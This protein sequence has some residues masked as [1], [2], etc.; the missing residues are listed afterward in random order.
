MTDNPSSPNGG[1]AP[2]TEQPGP[3][4]SILTQYVKDLSFENPR[5]PY[6]LQAG[7]A[8]PEIQ[9]Q[10]DVR[11][12]PIADG[13]YEVV[14]DLNVNAQ[15]GDTSVFLVELAYGGLFTLEN[16]PQ[17]SL[18]P[19]LLIECPRLLFPFA[20]RVVADATRDGG[21]PPLMID[22]IDFVTLFRRRVQQSGES[23]QA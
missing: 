18:Q 1:A 20:R 5:A 7:Q 16:I 9:I 8:R 21:F 2:S 19:L 15:S 13:Q 22:P 10:V 17:D 14:L 12:A 3:R 23:A 6:G 4:L 11:A